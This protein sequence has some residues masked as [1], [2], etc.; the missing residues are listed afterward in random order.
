MA[1]DFKSYGGRDPVTGR[2]NGKQDR[3]YGSR[4]TRKGTLAVKEPA[5]IPEGMSKQMFAQLQQ[6]DN[7]ERDALI[8]QA[9]A[10]SKFKS[11]V[12]GNGQ[13]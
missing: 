11:K 2:F 6:Q 13:L 7:R 5:P 4:K 8:E 9:I 10:R 1:G 12:I 3:F